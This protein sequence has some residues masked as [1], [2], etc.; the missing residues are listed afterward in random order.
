MIIIGIIRMGYDVWYQRGTPLPGEGCASTLA[1]SR[2]EC[3][4]HKETQAMGS[5]HLSSEDRRWIEKQLLNGES[6]RR[7]AGLLHVSHTTI[8]RE[9]LKR[10]VFRPGKDE[11]SLPTHC[12]KSGRC[13]RFCEGCTDS[14]ASFI[15]SM[16]C[17]RLM[18]PP[19]VCNACLEQPR[20]KLGKMFYHAVDAQ[21]DYRARLVESRR[22]M[23]L[24]VTE[25]EQIR[26]CT[27]DA[28]RRGQSPYHIVAA[29]PDIMP[30]CP[31]TLYRMIGCGLLPGIYRMDL[32][33]AS[34]MK[35]RKGKR[36][37]HKVD[38][39][40]AAGRTYDDYLAFREKNQDIAVVEMDTVEGRRGGRCLLTLS[41]PSCSL[42]LMFI[43]QANNS[44]SVIDWFN[45]IEKK[46][47]LEA[48]RKIFPVIL[49]DNGSEFSN[50]GALESSLEAGRQ[51]TRIFYCEPGRSWEKPKV[52]GSNGYMRTV[53]PKGVDIPDVT[54]EQV[55]EAASH[56]NSK[57]RKALGGKSPV[58][59]FKELHG[60]ELLGRLGLREVPP[61]EV[62][63]TPAVLERRADVKTCI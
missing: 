31:R 19:F 39:R 15:P 4:G 9:I 53:F 35:P 13:T 1:H 34:S 38:R 52:E 10:R 24:T 43:R 16:K 42:Q 44:Q 30:V 5:T 21:E 48:F 55:S 63:L 59:L 33:R 58:A 62:T 37:Q 61:K 45:A 54:Q 57:L 29:N 18:G 8:G 32:Q 3:Q 27:A 22:G 56:I 14:C 28:L 12:I 46:I 6:C 26:A 36:P 17:T 2:E 41:L 25:L 11:P 7:I 20:C 51:R 40:C 49:T 60:E 47:G 23:N 50:P